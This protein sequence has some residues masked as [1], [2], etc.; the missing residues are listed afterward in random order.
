M[1]IRQRRLA[2]FCQGTSWLFTQAGVKLYSLLISHFLLDPGGTAQDTVIYFLT[3]TVLIS[4]SE[5]F[6]THTFLWVA[7]K[8]IP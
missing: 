6:R 2:A 1:S 4:G 5:R 3:S 7:F 8:G